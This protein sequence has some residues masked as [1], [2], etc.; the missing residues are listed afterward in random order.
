MNGATFSFLSPRLFRRIGAALSS[1][2][3]A[4]LIMAA[5]MAA[6]Y[7]LLNASPTRPFQ[8]IAAT[9]LG[10][11]ALL[12]DA[13]AG[14]YLLGFLI[15]M[16]AAVL[17]AGFF[18]TLTLTR[19]VPRLAIQGA[20]YSMAVWYFMQYILLPMGLNF[21]LAARMSPEVF[22]ASHFAYGLSLVSLLR[23]EKYL[24]RKDLEELQQEEADLVHLDQRKAS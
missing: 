16:V 20:L 17:I 2:I 19:K 21:P 4:G 5:C 22:A 24:A 3:I 8:L 6:G 1:G 15:H 13:G 11:S 7:A 14:T 23:I 9:L 12:P 10:E 18:G